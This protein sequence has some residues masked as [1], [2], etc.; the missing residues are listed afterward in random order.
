LRVA[1]PGWSAWQVPAGQRCKSRLVSVANPGWSAWQIPAGQRG[2]YRLVSVAS[3]GWPAIAGQ[4]QPAASHP[5]LR[6]RPDP[7][8]RPGWPAGTWCFARPAGSRAGFARGKSRLVGVA[9]P[10]WSAWQIPSGQRGKSRQV[11]AASSGWPA[12]ARQLQPAASHP[13]LRTRP[14]LHNGRAALQDLGAS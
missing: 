4:L 7:S 3:P 2:K 1:G 12:I 14:A 11:R 9:G 13:L 8:Q 5:L 10:G 6:T